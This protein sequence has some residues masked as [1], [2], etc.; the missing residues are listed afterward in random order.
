MPIKDKEE[1]VIIFENYGS[2]GDLRSVVQI[3]NRNKRRSV[4]LVSRWLL[5]WS[6]LGFCFISILLCGALTFYFA[7]RPGLYQENCATRSCEKNLS[8]KCINKTCACE[9]NYI[10][11][12]KCVMKKNY[13]EQ[14]HTAFYCQDYKNINCID[15][16]CKCASSFYW[17]GVECKAK[18]TYSQMCTSN[19]QCLTSQYL[20]CDSISK[21]CT[22]D[23]YTRFWDKTACF[24]KRT[25]NESC[26]LNEQCITSK[27]LI[28]S[29]GICKFFILVLPKCHYGYCFLL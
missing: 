16:V 7:A 29:N 14:C 21:K 19:T 20:Y 11:I 23:N 15:G 24:P 26:S 1:P 4:L 6:S 12:D 28:C 5:Y 18:L 3:I 27:N 10:Y 13:S 9:S 2:N 25:L 17:T 22:C 8:L